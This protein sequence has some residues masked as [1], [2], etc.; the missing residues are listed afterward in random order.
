MSTIATQTFTYSV[1]TLTVPLTTIFTRPSSCTSRWTYEAQFYNSVSGGLLLQN[2]L[3][4][5]ADTACFPSSFMNNGRVNSA[6]VYSP[7]ACPLGYTTPALLQNN[8]ATTAI[9]C[10][11]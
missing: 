8:G 2:A 7:G 11:S 1:D 6:Q 9:C 3:T 5:P 10:Q 4:D